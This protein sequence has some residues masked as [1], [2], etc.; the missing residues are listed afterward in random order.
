MS[1]VYSIHK[2][3]QAHRPALPAGS[4]MCFGAAGVSA[5]CSMVPFWL[6]QV[7]AAHS[8]HSGAV[9]HAAATLLMQFMCWSKYH[10]QCSPVVVGAGT[11][12]ST[13]GGPESSTGWIQ[14]AGLIF[15]I[16]GLT[17]I[18]KVVEGQSAVVACGHR[19]WKIL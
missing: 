15:D 1:V 11:L 14:P 7:C 17:H 2:L 10:V 6:L 3:D 13:L 5:T 19:L 12:C 9:L 16:P 8:G 4:H 18:Y